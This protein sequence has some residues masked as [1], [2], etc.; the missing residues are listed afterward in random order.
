MLDEVRRLV[1]LGLKLVRGEPLGAPGD[2]GLLRAR[3]HPQRAR[4]APTA[5]ER[6][7]AM[8]LDKLAGPAVRQRGPAARLPERPRA[9]ALIKTLAGATIALVTDG[10]L[11]P[12]GNPDGIEALDATRFG[13]YR[14][15]ASPASMPPSTT[16]CT[17]ATTRRT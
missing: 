7:T 3:R 14:S 8:L 16:T 10:G 15:R 6:A 13:A 1:A 4:R 2:G 12:R 9:R 5:A 17:A 11:V